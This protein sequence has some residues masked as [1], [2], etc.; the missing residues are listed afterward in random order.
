VTTP[1]TNDPDRRRFLKTAAILGAASSLGLGAIPETKAMTTAS[2][3]RKVAAIRTPPGGHWVGNGFPVRTMVSYYEDGASI[4]P[5]LLL[6]YAAPYRFAGDEQRRGVGE[7]PHRGFE[8]V[9]IAYQGEVE[10]RDSAGHSGR[11]GPGDVQW[12]T[13]ASG[14]VHEEMHGRAFSKT[15]GTFEMAQIWVNLPPTLKMSAPRY[16]DIADATIPVVPLAGGKGTVRVIAGECLG[17]RGPAK[18]H[19]PVNLWD[20]RLQAKGAAELTMPDGYNVLVLVRQGSVVVN[21]DSAVKEGH[22]AILDRKGESFLIE[23]PG[24]SQ[25]L[26]LG[27]EPIPGAVVGQG[28]FVM[29]TDEEIRQAFA[30]YRAGRM[31]H[32]K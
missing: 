5:F 19:T 22:L 2:R 28:P 30:D 16:Q 8:T 9:T 21:G 31:G 26:V 10:H 11:I 29:N 14:V 20:V 24:D 1:R 17:A 7:H 6:D 4:S 23:S 3:R 27:G 25:V 18:T 15:G 12:M 13:A 32:L